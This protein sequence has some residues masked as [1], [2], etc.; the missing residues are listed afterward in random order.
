MQCTAS[1]LSPPSIT[2]CLPK[3]LVLS[4][5]K[6]SCH[7]GLKC[8][9][10]S[11]YIRYCKKRSKTCSNCLTSDGNSVIAPVLVQEKPAHKYETLNMREIQLNS[12]PVMNYET[13]GAELRNWWCPSGSCSVATNSCM[14]GPSIEKW[15]SIPGPFQ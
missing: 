14:R 13:G 6:S 10:A 15:L 8:V 5:N 12:A 9:G 1:L 11:A 7:R 3:M 4:T 2:N